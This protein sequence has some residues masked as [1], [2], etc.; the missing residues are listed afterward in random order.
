MKTKKYTLT[1]H[2]IVQINGLLSADIFSPGVNK[3]NRFRQWVVLTLDSLSSYVKSISDIVKESYTDS[4][5]VSLKMKKISSYLA[6]Y[7]KMRQK[8]NL[9]KKLL[10]IW[11]ILQINIQ[12]LSRDRISFLKKEPSLWMK[13]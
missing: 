9:K 5:Y 12:K 3:N 8:K 4:D 1:N 13:V 2:Q 7:K 10:L 11:M 6:K